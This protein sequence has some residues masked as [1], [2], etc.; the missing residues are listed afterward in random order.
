MRLMRLVGLIANGWPTESSIQRSSEESP[1]ALHWDSGA[2]RAFAKAFIAFDFASPNR[3]GPEIWPV[4]KPS[5]A[6]GRI[7]REWMANRIEHPAIQRRISIC[8]ALGQRSLPC[9][10]KGFHRV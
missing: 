5:H 6:L 7:D 9:V 2:C 4:H 3:A 8:A 10:C 1:Y